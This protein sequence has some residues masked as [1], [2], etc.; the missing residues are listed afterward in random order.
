[1]EPGTGYSVFFLLAVFI[2]LNAA[3]GSKIANKTL[4]LNK[5]R[6]QSE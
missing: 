4:P 2:R 3:D 5:R 6:T 1:M